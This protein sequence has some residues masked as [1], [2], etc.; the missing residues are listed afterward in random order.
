MEEGHVETAGSGRLQLRCLGPGTAS[1][2]GRPVSFRT[3]KTLTL[4]AY[5]AMDRGPHPRERIADVFWPGADSSAARDNLRTALVYLRQTLGQAASAVLITTKDTVGVAHG[6]VES[7]VDALRRACQVARQ[8][9]DGSVR[10]QIQAAVNQY[11]G[12]LLAEL[13]LPDAPEFETWLESQ[14]AY[15]RGVT[16]ELLSLLA[17]LQEE[18]GDHSGSVASLEQWTAIDPDDE[19]AWRRLIELQLDEGNLAGAHAAWERYRQTLEDMEATPGKMMAELHHRIM[20]ASF[21]GG[22]STSG[23]SCFDGRQRSLAGRPREW[24]QIDAAYRRVGRGGCEVLVI[25][26][27]P[28][29]VTR[30]LASEIASSMGAEGADLIVGRCLRSTGALPYIPWITG[31]RRRLETENAPEDLLDDQWLTELARLLPELLDRYP[32]LA[33]QQADPLTRG[34]IFEA[35]SRLGIA[36]GRRQPLAIVIDDAQWADPDTRDLVQYAVRR[37]AETATPVLLVLVAAVP[38]TGDLQAW[39]TALEGETRITQLRLTPLAAEG[40][41]TFDGILAPF[42]GSQRSRLAYTGVS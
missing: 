6:A 4:L 31:L 9:R 38:M 25:S 28:G 29:P 8:R 35:V 40:V 11:H 16:A 19:L 30:R 15:W 14:R 17:T 1:V 26:G 37:W 39:I 23:R 22:R 34:K 41:G 42:D 33:V 5:L 13:S 3:K 24:A 21:V 2:D 18:A 20:D 32:D 10:H 12:P 36:L 27:Q 7:D